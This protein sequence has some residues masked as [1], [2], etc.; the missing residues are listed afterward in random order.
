M[1]GAFEQYDMLL[2]VY[3]LFLLN[4]NQ[5]WEQ[6]LSSSLLKAMNMPV[7][8]FLDDARHIGEVEQP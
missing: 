6:Q 1:R 8:R 5:Q 3:A 4:D 7:G 2:L